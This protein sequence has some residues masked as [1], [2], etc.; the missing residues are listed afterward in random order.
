MS[1]KPVCHCSPNSPLPGCPGDRASKCPPMAHDK[2]VIARWRPWLQGLPEHAPAVSLN[3]GSTPLIHS[4]K[5]SALSGRRVFLKFEGL[6]PTG[7]FKD[8]GMCV[9]VSGAVADGARVLVCASTGNT[10]AAAAAYAARAG[11]SCLVLLPAGKISKGKLAQALVYGAKVAAVR[12]NFDA[13]LRVV[14]QFAADREFAVV[15]SIN[16]LRIEGQQTAAFEVVETLGGAPAAHLLPV[17]NAGNITAYWKGYTRFQAAGHCDT[18]PMMFGFQA[19]GSAPLVLGHP[20]E[21]PETLATA[22]RI[23]DPASA[24]GARAAIKDSNGGIDAVTDDEILDAQAMLARCEGIFVEPASAASVAGL[25]KMIRSKAIEKIPAGS[26]VVL[27]VTGNGLKDTDTALIRA[28]TEPV[29][30]DADWQDVR[31]RLAL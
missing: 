29:E 28:G 11:L 19:A 4:P 6:N 27:T 20:V 2:G 16:P 10:S 15:N 8:R 9:A 14:R 7:S 31:K 22:I 30:T 1:T 25:L 23:G 24:D 26:D 5:L 13:A 17:G 21:N 12:G 18:L 3:E